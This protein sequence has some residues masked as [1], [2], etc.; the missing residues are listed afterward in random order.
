[1]QTSGRGRGSSVGRGPGRLVLRDRVLDDGLVFRIRPRALRSR[2]SVYTSAAPSP[3]RDMP[4]CAWDGGREAR[5][6]LQGSSRGAIPGK[7]RQSLPL[8]HPLGARQLHHPRIRTVAVMRVVGG[9]GRGACPQR[10]SSGR[11]S[12]RDLHLVTGP[13]PEGAFSSPTLPTDANW[14]KKQSSAGGFCGGVRSM[15]GECSGVIVSH[16]TLAGRPSP[17]L[18]CPG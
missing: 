2:G 15:R 4:A 16:R 14:S 5:R 17:L 9:T 8:P 7:R 1:M 12:S 13:C 18:E 11:L 10:S 3:R 6:V